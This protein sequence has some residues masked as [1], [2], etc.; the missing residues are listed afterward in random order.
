[1]PPIIQRLSLLPRR[2]R[3]VSLFR[4]SSLPLTPFRTVTQ[5]S[6]TSKQSSAL[7]FTAYSLPPQ[8]PKVEPLRVPPKGITPTLP[9]QEIPAEGQ[10]RMD[11]SFYMRELPASAD[12]IPYDS[13]EG[14]KIFRSALEEGGLEA[15]FPLSQQFLT[16]EE[17]AC[18]FLFLKRFG[19]F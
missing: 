8:V 10:R 6:P 2:V 19:L 3:R 11:N 4:P 17:P 1:M 16:Q 7:S 18:K 14:K 5:L 12:L 9:G 13:V 15:F